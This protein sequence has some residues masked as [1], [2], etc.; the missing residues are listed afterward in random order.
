MSYPRIA[1]VGAGPAGLTL[2]RIL[3][4]NSIIPDV[5]ER[6]VSADYRPQGGSLDLHEHSGLYALREAKL[7]QE[8]HQYARYD[9]QEAKTFDKYGDLILQDRGTSEGEKGAKPEIDR[10]ELRNLLLQSID[11]KIVHWDYTLSS[12]EPTSNKT[13]DLH[14]K[15]GQVTRG[16][17]LVVGADG[18][19]SHVRPLVTSVAPFYSGLSF[20]ETEIPKPQGPKLND[21][22]IRVY[23]MFNTE[24]PEWV[25]R[26]IQGSP[27]QGRAKILDKFEGWAPMFLEVLRLTEGPLVPR[28]LYMF[29]V[30]HKW[31]ARSGVTLIG[32]AGHV[33]TPAAGE[34]VNMAMWDAAEL[35][36]AIVAGVRGGHLDEKVR[37]SEMELFNRAEDSARRTERNLRVFLSSDDVRNNVKDMVQELEQIMG[38]SLWA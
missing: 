9:S 35:A 11:P 37:E 27:A 26:F 36:K 7:W 3:V 22:S 20:I 25:D 2:A 16:Y 8:F 29:P 19:W 15:N 10:T 17:D 5:F 6:D 4:I 30:D 38:R 1:I 34:G 32:D 23:A 24:S 14:F 18:T 33:M 12:V 28:P 31:E 13:Y 21:N